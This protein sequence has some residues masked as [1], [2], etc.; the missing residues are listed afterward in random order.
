MAPVC[1]TRDIVERGPNAVE[2]DPARVHSPS[3][4]LRQSEPC[5]LGPLGYL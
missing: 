5:Y 4:M 3:G 1:E 2:C